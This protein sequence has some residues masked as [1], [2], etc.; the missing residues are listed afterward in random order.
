[1][2]K[3]FFIIITLISSQLFSQTTE[4][5][6]KVIDTETS[7]PVSDVTITIEDTSFSTKTDTAGQF[8][9]YKN[10]PTGE[11]IVSVE[12]NDYETKFL[13][14]NVAQGKKIEI[15]EIKLDLT[16]KAKKKRK[17]ILKELQKK[18][19]E[20]QKLKKKKLEQ[21]RKE[22]EERRKKI[23]KK[24]RDIKNNTEDDVVI[25]YTPTNTVAVT[26]NPVNVISETQKKYAEILGIAPE[27]I[28]NTKLYDF[29][30]SWMGTPYLLGG[31][32]RRGID[33]SSFTQLLYI[34]V[35]DEYI[36]RTA[37]K[38]YNSKSRVK[39]RDPKYLR[40]GDLMFFKSLDENGDEVVSHVGLY[41]RNG[42]FVNSTSKRG[43]NNVKGVQIC[44]IN[45]RYWRRKF[46]GAGRRNKK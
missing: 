40:E 22:A 45:D 11:Q 4:F 23:E 46:V 24:K 35:Y 34:K 13:I 20:A 17:K 31:E 9:F 15:K 30:D 8:Y 32:N 6:G 21:L 38:Q 25:T 12:K 1:M 41:L 42:Y 3:I 43:V 19:K 16:R 29:I 7:R 39:F 28:T 14:I 2:K 44:N 18:K 26:K 37:E 27:E 33:C 10:I 36:E 5:K